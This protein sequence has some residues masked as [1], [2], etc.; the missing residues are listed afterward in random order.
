MT[1]YEPYRLQMSGAYSTVEF[2]RRMFPRLITKAK[3]QPQLLDNFLLFVS[4]LVSKDSK[5]K[6]SFLSTDE[7]M[8]LIA[9]LD[10][11]LWKAKT[12]NRLLMDA[13]QT[14]MA[15]VSNLLTNPKIRRVF[16]ERGGRE[17]YFDTIR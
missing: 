9:S 11:Y 7:V 10:E 4:N 8:A 14:S 17:G 13:R 3:K 16:A 5:L 1:L 2:I 15:L 6:D 12:K